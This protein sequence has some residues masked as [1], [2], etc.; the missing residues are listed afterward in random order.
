MKILCYEKTNKQII[1]INTIKSGLNMDC[2]LW[3]GIT[4]LL[5]L[6]DV[7]EL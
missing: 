1:E 3:N 2:A 7:S 4:L 6:A 5:T